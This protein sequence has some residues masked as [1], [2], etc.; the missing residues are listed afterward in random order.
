MKNNSENEYC[1]KC[2][3]PLLYPDKPCPN[4]N[5]SDDINNRRLRFEE[6]IHIPCF[7]KALY[8]CIIVSIVL[9]IIISF[10][11][12]YFELLF[13][14]FLFFLFVTF[15]LYCLRL[16]KLLKQGKQESSSD[17]YSLKITTSKNI[18][19][20]YLNNEYQMLQIYRIRYFPLILYKSIIPF[21]KILDFSIK[22][23]N[24]VLTESSGGSALIGGLLFGG[25][26][27]ITGAI[28]GDKKSQ[29]NERIESF[30]ININDYAHPLFIFD[31]NSNKENKHNSTAILKQLNVLC[32]WLKII[33][34]NNQNQQD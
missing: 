2:G 15:I 7:E 1:S 32:G 5:K 29:F 18:F 3:I 28:L 13:Y 14:G 12:N 8:S 33:I 23:E 11:P 20:I 24:Q 30:I 6:K 4:C 16:N 21:D 31:I 19:D 27:M 17:D 22:T 25:A 34:N 9:L 10:N 26:G